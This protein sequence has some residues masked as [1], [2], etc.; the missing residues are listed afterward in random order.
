[1]ADCLYKKDTECISIPLEG[2]CGN[3]RTRLITTDSQF[4]LVD[5]Q[6]NNGFVMIEKSCHTCEYG[7]YE[8]QEKLNRAVTL[9][10]EKM[11]EAEHDAE[12]VDP[13]HYVCNLWKQRNKERILEIIA[14]KQDADLG[15]KSLDELKALAESM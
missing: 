9:L 6:Q 11:A 4:V 5:W 8:S 7:I 2:V 3:C 10:C 13:K 1:M 15:S 12:I 14:K